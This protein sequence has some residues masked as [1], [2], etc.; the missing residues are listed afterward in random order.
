MLKLTNAKF[1]LAILKLFHF[2]FSVGYFPEIWNQ[3]LITPIFKNGD[4]FHPNNY[5]CI[6]VNSNLGKVF[7]SIINVRILNFLNKHNVLSKIGFI[8]KHCMTDHIYTLHTM[9]DKYVQQ[10]NTKIYACFI[11]LKS[12][13]F[14]LAY[15][16]VLQSY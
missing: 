5:R 10:N 6:C 16:T 2:I 9:I 11:D 4:K 14:Y 1:Q 13:R 12:I 8:P 3:R 15:R 7:C